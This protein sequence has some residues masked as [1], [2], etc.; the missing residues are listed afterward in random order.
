[1]IIGLADTAV[2]NEKGA[3]LLVPLSFSVEI[4][5]IG[6]GRIEPMRNL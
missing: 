6:L 5:A 2:K 1:M 4:T 3:T